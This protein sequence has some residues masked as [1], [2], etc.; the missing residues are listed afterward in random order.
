M[1]GTF[2]LMLACWTLPGSCSACWGP[3]NLMLGRLGV[4]CTCSPG[5]WA[6]SRH[7]TCMLRMFSPMLGMLGQDQNEARHSNAGCDLP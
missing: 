5:C 1:W 2:R 3:P 4:L 7:V 6:I